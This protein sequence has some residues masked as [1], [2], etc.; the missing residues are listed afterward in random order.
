MCRE[1]NSE[2][3]NFALVWRSVW[4]GKC[5]YLLSKMKVFRWDVQGGKFGFAGFRLSVVVS[6]GQEMCV[7]A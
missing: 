4:E 5:V 2:S 3:Q 1:E 6:M 7:F